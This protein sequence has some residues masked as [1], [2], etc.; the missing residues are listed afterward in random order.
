MSIAPIECTGSHR[1]MGEAQGRATAETLAR[2]D[3]ALLEL[4]G[5]AGDGLIGRAGK[6]LKPIM[7]KGL[8]LV[9]TKLLEGALREHYP[10]Q[11]ERLEGIAAGSGVSLRQ[12]FVGPAV[13][14]LL[15]QVVP[16][17]ACT[18]VAI[19]R[20]GS[21]NGEPII[22]K[23]F[24]YP[25]AALEMYIARISRPT[26][27]AASVDITAAPMAGCHEGVNEYGLAVA[28]NYGHFS[29][30]ATARVSITT[31]V[32]ELLEQCDSVDGAI[33]HL[34]ERPRDG[35]A[36]LMLADGGGNIA[37]VELGPDELGV[38]RGRESGDVLVHA[39]HAVTEIMQERDVPREARF[40]RWWRPTEMAGTRFHE[41]SEQRHARAQQILD[42]GSPLA[43][44]DLR[45]LLADHGGN[46]GGSD[47]TI[48][49]HG[50]YYVTTCSVLLFPRRRQVAVMFGSPCTARFVT[51]SL[52]ASPG[53]QMASYTGT[54]KKN[55]LSGGFWELHTDGGDSY[56]LRGGDDSLRVEGQRVE[57]SGT[58]DEGGFGIGM[59]G[60]YLDVASWKAA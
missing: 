59:T 42:D 57:V 31:L 13:E 56:Q 6:L 24:D 16:A 48:C 40:P 46:E 44:D 10:A 60:A 50:P 54:V 19:T 45:A 30:K 39:N 41:S 4:A 58:V 5:L 51:L 28:Y 47:H 33:E 18:A 20:E 23:N 52:H 22:A 11:Y 14:L 3:D 26:E 36:L 38:R 49:R 37:S 8:S 2:I 27:L 12:L 55:D 7:N 43:A 1:E 34:R 25:P 53:A 32:Q 15:N 21:A 17:R 9:G 35:G 29:G